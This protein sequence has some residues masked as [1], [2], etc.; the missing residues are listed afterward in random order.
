[1]GRGAWLRSRAGFRCRS[2][3][4]PCRRRGIGCRSCVRAVRLS[5]WVVGGGL[6][7]AR[8]G[9][10]A[11]IWETPESVKFYYNRHTDAFHRL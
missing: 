10:T 9:G 11:D 5:V 6:Y 8:C 3:C 4:T 1:M 2:R 7:S